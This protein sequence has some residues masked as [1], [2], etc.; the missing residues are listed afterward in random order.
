[1]LSTGRKYFQMTNFGR[2]FLFRKYKNSQ[3]S[4]GGGNA[5]CQNW[6]IQLLWPRLGAAEMEK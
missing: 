6:N 1:M 2:D 3:C 5:S 4:T